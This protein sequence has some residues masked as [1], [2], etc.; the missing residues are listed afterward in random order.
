MTNFHNLEIWCH[1]LL[2]CS[3]FVGMQMGARI[4]GTVVPSQW[5]GSARKTFILYRGSIKLWIAESDKARACQTTAKPRKLWFQP[6]LDLSWASDGSIAYLKIVPDPIP[7]LSSWILNSRVVVRQ[8]GL[9]PLLLSSEVEVEPEEVPNLGYLS[10]NLDFTTSVVTGAGKLGMV[11]SFLMF[12]AF[13]WRDGWTLRGKEYEIW[14]ALVNHT[15]SETNV[16]NAVILFR[17]PSP[18]SNKSR[19]EEIVRPRLSLINVAVIK[20]LKRQS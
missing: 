4:A 17:S 13:R 1:C 3:L 2:H 11:S 14:I 6:N 8:F 20:V 18:R 19:H 12:N 10:G 5:D 15:W 16:I 9:D 7:K